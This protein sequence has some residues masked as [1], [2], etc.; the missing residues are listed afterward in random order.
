MI[1]NWWLNIFFKKIQ[2]EKKTITISICIHM[3]K[4]AKHSEQFSNLTV[5]I[6]FFQTEVRIKN[7]A[8]PPSPPPPLV[9]CKTESICN[10]AV[11]RVSE[12]IA[13][14]VQRKNFFTWKSKGGKLELFIN[15]MKIFRLMYT[16]FSLSRN[17]IS[18]LKIFQKIKK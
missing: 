5:V 12:V 14:C 13:F 10:K 17:C 18:I 16:S 1:C 2:W 9:G 6:H 4:N 15:L 3:G 7:Y 8:Y 11:R